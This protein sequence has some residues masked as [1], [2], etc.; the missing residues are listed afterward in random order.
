MAQ[1]KADEIRASYDADDL[2]IRGMKS[3]LHPLGVPSGFFSDLAG[4]RLDRWA[5]R[6]KDGDVKQTSAAIL[7]A[8][9]FRG[10]GTL[11]AGMVSSANPK[12]F[13]GFHLSNFGRVFLSTDGIDFTTVS[14]GVS[15]EITASSGQF[16]DTR[17]TTSTS[18]DPWFYFQQVTDRFLPDPNYGLLGH[19]YL[20]VQHHGNKPRVYSPL[21]EHYGIVDEISTPQDTSLLKS[22]PT[23]PAYATIT[24]AGISSHSQV[25]GTSMT[26]TTQGTAPD[27]YIRVRGSN[28]VN[29]DKSRTTFNAS[30]SI[31]SAAGVLSSRQIVMLIK[32]NTPDILNKVAFSVG[33]GT[34][35]NEFYDP[36]DATKSAYTLVPADATGKYF[37]AA[38][39]LEPID[40]W[41]I[42]SAG[43]SAITQFDTEWVAANFTGTVDLEIYAICGSGK[44]P[45]GRRHLLTYMRQSLGCESKGLRIDTVQPELVKN[46]GGADLDGMRIPNVDGRVYVNYK[47]YY[48]NTS[49]TERDKGTN[50]LVIYAKDKVFD[51]DRNRWLYERNYSFV[52]SVTLATFLGTWSFSSGSALGI[53]TTTDST[54][55][56][57]LSYKAPDPDTLPIPQGKAMCSA[58]ARL[59]VGA[60]PTTLGYSTLWISDAN[61]PGRFRQNAKVLANGQFDPTA[62]TTHQLEDEDIMTLVPS[63]GRYQGTANVYCF[64][65]KAVWMIGRDVN[66]IERIATIGTLSPKSCIEIDGALF[67]L[68]SDRRW[69]MLIPGEAPIDIGFDIQ[70][71]LNSIP[72]A[73]DAGTSRL[74]RVTS[75]QQGKRVYLAY[76][77]SGST[78]TSVAVYNLDIQAIES[79][80]APTNPFTVEQFLPWVNAG[81]KGLYAFSSDR[82][83]YQY[84]QP[85]STANAAVT[86]TTPEFYGPIKR[87]RFA[88]Q[89]TYISC[90]DM[91]SVTATASVSYYKGSG[92]ARTATLSLDVTDDRLR[93]W[94]GT[95]SST[96]DRMG[97]SAKLSYTAT[98]PGGK[99]IFSFG[100][101]LSD[102]GQGTG[103]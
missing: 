92:T 76:G 19:T 97:T 43:L 16:G 100:A 3:Y 5:V 44:D 11:R 102:R 22:I 72:G 58:N 67:F 83:F 23:F 95:W 46:V 82:E 18:H 48:Q 39:P 56:K 2:P 96:G 50:L 88:V 81:V 103:S 78:N 79:V 17:F 8:S 47:L 36:T 24:T 12:L 51:P 89:R 54:N 80:D 68:S 29:G 94:F 40:G 73:S 101:E 34:A 35:Q 74:Y 28:P 64:T 7:A 71:K 42:A 98:M 27:Q 63:A 30:F 45:G 10:A 9:T 55:L 60:R 21:Y 33:D 59:Y 62:G 69:I 66:R 26:N 99:Y 77:T 86:M 32:S 61:N 90:E 93:K 15:G 53:L 52:S 49:T 14:A 57:K 25:T 1:T 70:D 75:G 6:V 87:N 41:D 65:D 84:E 4:V 31:G 20:V 85:S 13:A 38:F 37:W 91:A